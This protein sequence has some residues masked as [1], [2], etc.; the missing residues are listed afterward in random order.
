MSNKNS[1]NPAHSEVIMSAE[2]W[3]DQA[4]DEYQYGSATHIAK[5]YAA[6]FHAAQL[7]KEKTGGL[8]TKSMLWDA[9]AAGSVSTWDKWT[10]GMAEF[11]KYLTE[12]N[13]TFN[14]TQ[15]KPVD[16]VGVDGVRGEIDWNKVQ[17]DFD[18]WYYNNSSELKDLN[19]V[20]WLKQRISLGATGDGEA[21]KLS[22]ILKKIDEV[23]DMY[24]YKVA[25]NHD[26]YSTYNEAWDDCCGII[27]ERIKELLPT[28]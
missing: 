24:P 3:L 27:K 6:Y 22:D 17:L 4:D 10:H 25:G 13:I 1:N 12:N 21:V 15:S 16:P 8:V 5:G 7:A 14:D 19:I 28:K 18:K 20:N 23:S 9:Y 26:T 11:E 2:E